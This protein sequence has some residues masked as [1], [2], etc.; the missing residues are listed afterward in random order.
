MYV[1]HE[2]VYQS[3]VGGATDKLPSCS[4]HH[5]EDFQKSFMLCLDRSVFLG[6]CNE[7]SKIVFLNLRI[8]LTLLIFCTHKNK[9]HSSVQMRKLLGNREYT[10]NYSTDF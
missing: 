4:C 7:V 10:E 1:V 5:F 3:A 8:K 2:G 6:G 9:S